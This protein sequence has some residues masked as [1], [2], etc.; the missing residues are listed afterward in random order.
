MIDADPHITAHSEGF[1]SS[2]ALWIKAGCTSL[3][4]PIARLEGSGIEPQKAVGHGAGDEHG[5]DKRECEDLRSGH[6]LAS[7]VVTGRGVQN[8]CSNRTTASTQRPITS[9]IALGSISSIAATKNSARSNQA[10]TRRQ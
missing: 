10:A 5:C 1:R 2:R 3:A 7:R 6:V 4:E 9:V 8:F